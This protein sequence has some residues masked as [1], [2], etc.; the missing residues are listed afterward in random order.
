MTSTTHKGYFDAEGIEAFRRCTSQ[1]INIYP[2]PTSNGTYK[3]KAK[4]RI[5]VDYGLRKVESKEVYDQGLS[6]TSK[7]Q[8]LYKIISKK[9]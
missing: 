2:V 7:I 6:L 9:I 3:Q 4:V 5:I 8:E 1:G